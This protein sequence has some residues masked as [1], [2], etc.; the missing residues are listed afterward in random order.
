MW[1]LRKLPPEKVTPAM[2]YDLSLQHNLV[3]ESVEQ[4]L[5][6]FRSLAGGG[7]VLQIYEGEDKVATLIVSSLVPRESAELDLIPKP[8]YFRRGFKQ[9]LV[10]SLQPLW[11]VLFEEMGV[12]RVTAY[13]PK[14]RVRTKRALLACGFEVEGVMREGARMRNK[15]P[16]DLYLMG[17]LKKDIKT[18]AEEE[19]DGVL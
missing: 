13:V 10:S 1:E 18:P 6:T 7:L 9:E 15:N 16:E 3:P 14:S 5:H 12:R 4:S 11:M 19:A 8:Q 2:V 17:L